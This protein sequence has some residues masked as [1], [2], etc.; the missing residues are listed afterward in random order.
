[1]ATR[2]PLIPKHST[3]SPPGPSLATN[4]LWPKIARCDR[5]S[6]V[7]EE[8]SSWSLEFSAWTWK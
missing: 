3:G 4:A 6:I 5:V 1:V 2:Q 7:P 8:P